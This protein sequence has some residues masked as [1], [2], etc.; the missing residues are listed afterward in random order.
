MSIRYSLTAAASAAILTA[1][2]VSFAA[3][4]SAAA[5]PDP[6]GRW[7]DV[8]ATYQDGQCIIAQSTVTTGPDGTAG[9]PGGGYWQAASPDG[10]VTASSGAGGG[11]VTGPAETTMDLTLTAPSDCTAADRCEC[12]T[13][14]ARPRSP[15]PEPQP[16]PQPASD[17][18]TPSPAEQPS[19]ADTPKPEP[20][21]TQPAGLPRTG[22]TGAF[23]L[24]ALTGLAAGIAACLTL[25]YRANKDN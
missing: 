18:Q 19:P 2:A 7:A 1:A 16:E 3:A 21:T 9:I 15:Q 4:P 10:T 14:D 23:S 17:A 20:A 25:G 13:L 22:S 8:G 6:C 5:D 11:T 12:L 24:G